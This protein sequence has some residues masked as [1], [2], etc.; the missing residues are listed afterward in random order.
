M[1]GERWGEGVVQAE[2]RGC[3][4]NPGNSPCWFLPL[5][6]VGMFLFSFTLNKTA[7]HR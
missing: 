1:G 2:E 7:N 3:D 4:E 6:P 5:E